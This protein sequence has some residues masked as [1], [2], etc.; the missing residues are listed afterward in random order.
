MRQA[1][2]KAASKQREML[3]EDKGSEDEEKD[4]DEQAFVDRKSAGFCSSVFR[5][6]F[7]R[8]TFFELLE[9]SL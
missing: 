4:E 7:R 9:S 8:V 2:S 5:H 3:L 6:R 1:A